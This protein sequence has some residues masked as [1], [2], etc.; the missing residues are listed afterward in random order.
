MNIKKALTILSLRAIQYRILFRCVFY[1]LHKSHSM[2][3]LG[4]VHNRRCKAHISFLLQVCQWKYTNRISLCRKVLYKCSLLKKEFR[5][6]KKIMRVFS[7]QQRI[8]VKVN[9]KDE[10]LEREH[11]LVAYEIYLGVIIPLLAYIKHN[12][13]F[14]PVPLYLC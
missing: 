2:M 13:L 7:Y 8:L 14:V 3:K 6:C 10:K 12:I 4:H 5:M 9:L 11:F 1:I